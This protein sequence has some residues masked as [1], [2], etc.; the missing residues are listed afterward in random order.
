ME[1]DSSYYED[2]NEIKGII[3]TSLDENIDKLE[4]L[5]IYK[6]KGKYS[7]EI[8]KQIDEYA[9]YI[10]SM[11]DEKLNEL[12]SNNISKQEEYE[13]LPNLNLE[14]MKNKVDKIFENSKK[15]KEKK[16]DFSSF[17]NKIKDCLFDDLD[18]AYNT[19]K[20]ILSFF[21]NE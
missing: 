17:E 12:I 11:M 1:L 16:D 14:D 4:D 3:A 18:Q 6:L 21:E 9:K 5:M 2:E 15:M 7:N 19:Y 13:V 8:F 20:T 10:S